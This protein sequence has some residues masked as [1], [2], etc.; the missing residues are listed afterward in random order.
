MAIVDRMNSARTYGAAAPRFDWDFERI[1]PDKEFVG[2]FMRSSKEAMVAFEKSECDCV[3]L[4]TI[5]GRQSWE[6]IDIPKNKIYT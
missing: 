1:G 5:L 6:S 4:I 3:S 2:R